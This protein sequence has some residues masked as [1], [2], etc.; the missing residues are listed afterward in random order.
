MHDVSIAVNVSAVQLL[1]DNLA[2]AVREIQSRYQLPH[3][4]LHVELTE[5]VV[6][7]Q[8]QVAQARMQELREI[9]VPVAI[10]DFGTGFSSMAYLRNLPLDWLKIDR[11]FVQDVHVDERN[12]SICR[13]L[14]AL[15]GGLGL[16]TI[17]EGVEQEGELEWLRNNGCDQAQGYLLGRPAPLSQLLDSICGDAP[18]QSDVPVA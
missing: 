2:D 14:I 5:S 3:G 16:G 9:G 1:G 12:A 7:R 11:S 6:L 18:G 15:A 8:P 10:D 4:A 17:A 13:A